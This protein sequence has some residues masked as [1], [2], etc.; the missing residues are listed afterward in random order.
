MNKLDAF[1]LAKIILLFKDDIKKSPGFK[2][3]K[4]EMAKL[5]SDKDKI[6]MMKLA[7]LDA[8]AEYYGY[9][10]FSTIDKLL[11]S[12]NVESVIV[13]TFLRDVITYH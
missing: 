3:L 2:R 12:P 13:S 9:E 7:L 10:K 5:K 1:E 4:M 6:D 8:L 11:D